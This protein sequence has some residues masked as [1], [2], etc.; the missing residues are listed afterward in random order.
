MLHEQPQATCY[1]TQGN[2][3]LCMTYHPLQ[4]ALLGKTQKQTPKAREQSMVRNEMLVT[5][6]AMIY[7]LNFPNTCHVV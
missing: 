1:N 2:I 6:Q 3:S 7:H 5:D 4:E